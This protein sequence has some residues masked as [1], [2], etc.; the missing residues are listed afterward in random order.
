V[1]QV[2]R[3]PAEGCRRNHDISEEEEEGRRIEWHGIRPLLLLV[4]PRHFRSAID[5]D[6]VEGDIA[7]DQVSN[8]SGLLSLLL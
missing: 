8:G 4:A 1:D 3:P 6:S 2:G 7:I 5:I